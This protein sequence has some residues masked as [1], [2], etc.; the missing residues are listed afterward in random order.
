MMVLLLLRGFNFILKF[1]TNKSYFYLGFH[2]NFQG[3]RCMNRFG[4]YF[5]L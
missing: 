3:T 2:P 5:P 4:S 1:R